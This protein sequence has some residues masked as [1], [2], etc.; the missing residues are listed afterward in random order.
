MLGMRRSPFS[1]T[2]G[3]L[4]DRIVEIQN[5]AEKDAARICREILSAIYHLHEKDI[6]HRDLKVRRRFAIRSVTDAVPLSPKTFFS[7]PRTPTTSN[8]QTLVSP[9]G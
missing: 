9:S 7:P 4:F 6:V 3:E 1:L 2:G 5:Y 8:S